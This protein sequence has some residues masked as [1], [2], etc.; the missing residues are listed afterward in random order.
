MKRCLKRNARNKGG[1]KPIHDTIPLKINSYME[2]ISSIAANRYLK[3][4]DK[5]AYYCNIS[6]LIKVYSKFNE[7]YSKFNNTQI[8]GK[9]I[10]FATFYKYIRDQ[11]KKAHRFS[12]LC[13]YCEKYKVRENFVFQ[14]Y[15]KKYKGLSV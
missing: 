14:I 12:D 5:N 1:R 11:F 7:A 13:D 8:N 3:K 15:Y 4:I 9:P 6:L 2:S 10:S